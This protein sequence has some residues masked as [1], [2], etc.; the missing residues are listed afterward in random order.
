[1]VRPGPPSWRWNRPHVVQRH[2]AEKRVAAQVEFLEVGGI[3]TH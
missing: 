3:D 1:M 2:I